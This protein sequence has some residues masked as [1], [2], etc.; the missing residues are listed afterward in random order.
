MIDGV[1]CA[2][3]YAKDQDQD[4]QLADQVFTDELFEIGFPKV[5]AFKLIT[6]ACLY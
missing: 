4:T 2:N 5:L 3:T 1:F 6:K